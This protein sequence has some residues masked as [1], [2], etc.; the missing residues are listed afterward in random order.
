MIYAETS[1][2]FED[3]NSLSHRLIFYRLILCLFLLYEVFS[4][5]MYNLIPV[6]H[7]SNFVEGSKISSLK[8]YIL[9]NIVFFKWFGALSCLFFGIGIKKKVSGLITLGCFLV[10]VYLNFR[11]GHSSSYFPIFS[12]SILI[13]SFT[14]RVNDIKER[15]YFTVREAY[16]FL[17]IW[18]VLF[19]FA[20]GASKI[21]PFLKG[22]SW[23][24]GHTIQFLT[25]SR[26]FDSPIYWLLD[27]PLFAYS[28]LWPFTIMSI[29]GALLE[30]SAF[31]CLFSRRFLSIFTVLIVFFHFNLFLLGTFATLQY[32]TAASLFF[33]GVSKLV[34]YILKRILHRSHE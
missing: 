16:N 30:L 3:D 33:P 4:A 31:F 32:A 26:T 2:L 25:I 10:L 15:Y 24:E 17:L 6:L 28:L 27:Q 12:V 34:N 14:S 11:I 20:A 23:I 9:T 8:F 7:E 19:Y 5:D 29:F 18:Y 1:P 22:L 21:T 13:L